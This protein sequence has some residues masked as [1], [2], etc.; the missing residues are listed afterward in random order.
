MNDRT[1]AA[2]AVRASSIM[3]GWGRGPLNDKSLTNR[4]RERGETVRDRPLACLGT[5]QDG[6]PKHP[7]YLK[8]TLQPRMWQAA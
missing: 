8:G 4:I 5:N 6:S 7:L 2:A 1:I 3:V